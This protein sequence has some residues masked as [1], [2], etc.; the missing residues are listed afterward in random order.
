MIIN[1]RKQPIAH[2]YC[3]ARISEQFFLFI[4]VHTQIVFTIYCRNRLGFSPRTI[5]ETL[6]LPFGRVKY[7]TVYDHTLYVRILM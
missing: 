4:F 6:H 5:I 3:L 1:K 2:T 7:Q